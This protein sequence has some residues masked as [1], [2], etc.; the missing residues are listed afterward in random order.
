MPHCRIHT[1]INPFPFFA[2]E[3]AGHCVESPAKF[4]LMNENPSGCPDFFLKKNL[5]LDAYRFSCR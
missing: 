3:E 2:L 5:D 1:K 4:S